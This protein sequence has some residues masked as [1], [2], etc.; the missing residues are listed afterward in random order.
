MATRSTIWIKEGNKR[1]GVYCHF[2][3][4]LQGVGQTLLDYYSKIDKVKQLISHGAISALRENICSIH[5][6]NYQSPQKD[7]CIFYHRDRGEGL[8]IYEA[9]KIGDMNDYHEEYMY[10]FENDQW[11]VKQYDGEFVSLKE[12][13]KNE[14]S[15]TYI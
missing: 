13:I 5:P 3:G 10:M 6:H 12:A 1:I 2:D 4:Y 11:Q 8:I 9:A 15:E 14:P 7:T